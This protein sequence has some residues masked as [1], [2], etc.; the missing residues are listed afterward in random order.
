VLR[1]QKPNEDSAWRRCRRE[2]IEDDGSHRLHGAQVLVLTYPSSTLAYSSNKRR[3]AQRSPAL[4]EQLLLMREDNGEGIV[5]FVLT[6]SGS[7]NAE[8]NVG[9]FGGSP[10]LSVG[11]LAD[12]RT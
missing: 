11:Q 6:V 9:F 5:S 10:V 2:G 7:L 1:A 12:D 3:L 8:G 4:T